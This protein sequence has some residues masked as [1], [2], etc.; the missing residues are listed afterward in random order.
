MRIRYNYTD[1][2]EARAKTLFSNPPE[3]SME[4]EVDGRL[5]FGKLV[6]R[7]ASGAHRTDQEGRSHGHVNYDVVAIEV[8]VRS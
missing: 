7:G 5:T 2:P 3:I 4:V 8:G 1:T 6:L